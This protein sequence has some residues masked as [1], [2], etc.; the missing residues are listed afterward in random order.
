MKK[1]I[2]LIFT[3]IVLITT[4]DVHAANYNLKELIPVGTTTT[5]VTKRFSYKQFYYNELEERIYFEGIKNIY[6]EELPV[7]F[8]I[9]LFDKDK[10]N[11]GLINY[12]DKNNNILSPDSEI[13]FSIDV[14]KGYLGEEFNAS[15]IKYIALLEDNTTCKVEGSNSY[16]G[17]KVDEIG[18]YQGSEL[19]DSSLLAVQ[20][21]GFIAGVI[22]VVFLYQFLFTNNFKNMDGN[23][24]RDVLKNYKKDS[25][26]ANIFGKVE[27]SSELPEGISIVNKSKT[28]EMADKE[29]LENDKS[30]RKEND[31]YDMY[32]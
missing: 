30:K 7:S 12:C 4:C 5:I 25:A 27:E 23:E 9:A 22:V 24:I 16:I 21:I 28:V 19:S 15:D 18:K 26:R 1:I 29:A 31:L 17:Q 2:A 13:V 8:S 6:Q 14:K 3:F 20:I 10:L 32:K 11:I